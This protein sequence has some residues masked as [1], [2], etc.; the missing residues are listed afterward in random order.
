MG[1]NFFPHGIT[2]LGD[3]GGAKT[4]LFIFKN[5]CMGHNGESGMYTNGTVCTREEFVLVLLQRNCNNSP[6]EVNLQSLLKIGR[7]TA[8]DEAVYIMLDLRAIAKNENKKAHQ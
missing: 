7:L 3:F 5:A 8:V 4:N 2:K 1:T 6:S